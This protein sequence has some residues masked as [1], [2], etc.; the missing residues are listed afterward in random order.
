MSTFIF[1]GWSEYK[2]EAD[3]KCKDRVGSIETVHQSLSNTLL[4][5]AAVHQLILCIFSVPTCFW[6]DPLIMF[7]SLLHIW[8]WIHSI[9]KPI[10][11]NVTIPES[12]QNLSSPW[13]P[14]DSS[15]QTT[16]PSSTLP[17]APASKS[18][19]LHIGYRVGSCSRTKQ[20]GTALH[21][22]LLKTPPALEWCCCL[23]LLP[24]SKLKQLDCRVQV[25]KR[26]FC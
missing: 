13:C 16:S 23:G 1:N 19:G 8:P 18:L 7:I 9:T 26:T 10:P 25:W 15:P 12:S 4:R 21:S 22:L 20:R 5:Y 6:V 3:L 11:M 14:A 24:T 17:S 2:Y